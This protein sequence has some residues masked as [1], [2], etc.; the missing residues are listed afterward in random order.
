MGGRGSGGRG[1]AAAALL[2]GA[3]VWLG[4][5]AAL[6]DDLDD[7]R[8]LAEDA[9]QAFERVSNDKTFAADFRDLARRAKGIFIAPEVIRG[10]FILG[11]AGG[12]GVFLVR[13]EKS[14]AWVGPAFYALGAASIG[15]QA[16]VD[17]SEVV[18][19]AMT[20]R[21]VTALLSAGVKLG[22]NASVAFGP[23][24]GGVSAATI[25][26]SAD[27]FAY[28]LSKWLYAGFAVDGAVVAPRHSLNQAYYGVAVSPTD[29]LIRRQVTSPHAAGLIKA[30]A[31][32]AGGR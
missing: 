31:E 29:I 5:G 32:V 14:G 16:G 20:E 6:G 18:L 9:R 21:G 10:A 27:I 30:V 4:P 7:A 3:L 15:L 25:N 19:L 23:V 2:L 13:D 12:G 11:G 28:S 1:R 17:S 24:G 26:L 8:D 22:A